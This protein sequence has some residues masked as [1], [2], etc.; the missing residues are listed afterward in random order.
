[1]ADSYVSGAPENIRLSRTGDADGAPSK[2]IRVPKTSDLIAAHIRSMI[3]RG[4]L[5][6]GDFLQPEGQLLKYFATSRPTLREAI[7]ILES[8][9]LITIV[10]GSRSGARVHRP[11]VDNVARYAGFALQTDGAT[12]GDLYEARLA[13]EPFAAGLAAERRDP[14]A[15]AGV[16][17]EYVRLCALLE[18][19]Q[20]T[21]YR[22]RLAYFHIRVV[23]AS[24]NKTLSLMNRLLHLVLANHQRRFRA[25]AMHQQLKEPLAEFYSSGMARLEKIADLIEAGERAEAEAYWRSHIE[26][27]NKVWLTGYDPNALIDLLD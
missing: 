17:E 7:R 27:G 16:R 1:M 2:V 20:S 4:E 10:R 26:H 18:S 13:V 9:R 6:E 24:G 22:E 23:D 8:E 21:T 19:G 3:I 11:S 12:L 5:Q 15:I 25:E 14:Q